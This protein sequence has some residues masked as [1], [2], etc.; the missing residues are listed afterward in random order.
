MLPIHACVLYG[1]RMLPI[2][3]AC[4]LYVIGSEKTTLIAQNLEMY[5]FNVGLMLQVCSL[6]CSLFQVHSAFCYVVMGAN[7]R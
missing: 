1:L 6:F 2:H 7:A 5:F 4:L 3:H